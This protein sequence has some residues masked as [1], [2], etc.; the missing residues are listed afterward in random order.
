MRT[1]RKLLA[2]IERC[3][4]IGVRAD[5]GRARARMPVPINAAGLIL[6]SLIHAETQEGERCF[7]FANW[8]FVSIEHAANTRSSFF[9]LSPA[10]DDDAEQP[11]ADANRAEHEAEAAR[12]KLMI[13]DGKWMNAEDAT[14]EWTRGLR[15]VIT[16]FE[17]FLTVTLARDLA[18]KHQLDLK[19]LVVEIREAFRKHRGEVSDAAREEAAKLPEFIEETS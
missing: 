2:R 9:P 8:P 15:Q 19:P 10:P 12:R 18:N 5:L 11:A 4:K 14:R 16:G 1:S 3:R 13:D 17:T 6:P 7:R